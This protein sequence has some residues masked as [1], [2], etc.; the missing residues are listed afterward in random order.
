MQIVVILL[1]ETGEHGTFPVKYLEG[2][3]PYE[4]TGALN[5]SATKEVMSAMSALNKEGTTILMVTHDS[6]LASR[7]NRVLYI[8]DGQIKGEYRFEGNDQNNDKEREEKLAC[9]LSD[10]DW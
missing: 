2:A 4:P 7:C 3:Y 8:L 9:W 10:Y 5:K 1:I 6:K